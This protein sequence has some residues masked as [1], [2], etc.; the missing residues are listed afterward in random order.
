VLAPQ[1]EGAVSADER[2]RLTVRFQEAARQALAAVPRLENAAPSS[3]AAGADEM[4]ATRAYCGTEVCQVILLRLR[5]KDGSEL[6]QDT[7]E[8]PR[9]NLASLPG[10]A[11]PRLRQAYADRR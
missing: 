6:W 5:G 2:D 8:I 10:R 11:A 7:L 9:A 4:I 1:I 3:P